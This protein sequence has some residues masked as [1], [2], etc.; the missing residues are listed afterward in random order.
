MIAASAA[1]MQLMYRSDM[2]QKDEVP[3]TSDQN[4]IPPHGSWVNLGRTRSGVAAPPHRQEP[5]K[6]A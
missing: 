6:V 5:A 1:A 2:L 4:E 3:D